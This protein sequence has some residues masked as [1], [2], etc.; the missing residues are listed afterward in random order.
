MG[1]RHHRKDRRKMDRHG[2]A[3]TLTL[4]TLTLATAAVPPG[5]L[6]AVFSL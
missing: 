6:Q 4:A 5:D 3:A 2:R 1:R